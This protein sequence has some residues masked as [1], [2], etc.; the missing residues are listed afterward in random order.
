MSTFSWQVVYRP[1]IGRFTKLEEP[2]ARESLISP[3]AKAP[4]SGASSDTLAVS[5]SPSTL[6]IDATSIQEKDGPSS[7]ATSAVF[8]PL[9]HFKAVNAA[10]MERTPF[11]I[12]DVG[13]DDDDSDLD[14]VHGEDDDQ[15]MDEVS[16]SFTLLF[17]MI[18][19]ALGGCFFGGTRF[20]TF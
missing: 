11:A 20:R 15:V 18:L 12:D 16:D 13:D 7:A 1:A 5:N 9:P 2:T 3:S 8:S 10:F 17:S 4:L 14:M 19:S 6:S